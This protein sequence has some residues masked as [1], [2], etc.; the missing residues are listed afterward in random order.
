MDRGLVVIPADF[1]ESRPISKRIG[2]DGGS[3]RLPAGTRD[4]LPDELRRKRA[5]EDCCAACSSAGHMPRRNAEFERFDVLE[6]GLGNSLT[7]ETFLF[8]DRSG[9]Q[10]ALRPE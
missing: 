1:D 9:T 3:V 10:L 2:R 4:W 7:A 6:L 8:N 5:V